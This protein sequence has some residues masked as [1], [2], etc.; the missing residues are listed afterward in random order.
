MLARVLPPIVLIAS[1]LLAG[2]RHSSSSPVIAACPNFPVG[3]QASL[4]YPANGATAVAVSTTTF[5]IGASAP[6]APGL[7]LSVQLQ[8]A[9]GAKT[10]LLPA[11]LPSPL[12]TPNSPPSF[13]NPSYSA[14]SL[15]GGTALAAGN[16]YSLVAAN[17]NGTLCAP[18]YT[19]TVGQFKT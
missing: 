13:P 4:V 3:Y 15:P 12:P 11:V 16:T 9:A 1:V 10:T 19:L 17:T 18:S 2:C 6:S 14:F 8:A 7:G 5:V